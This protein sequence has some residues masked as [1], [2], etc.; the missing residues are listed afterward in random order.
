MKQ[1]IT[2]LAASIIDLAG[3]VGTVAEAAGRYG[4][5]KRPGSERICERC[6]RL[7]GSAFLALCILCDMG[8]RRLRI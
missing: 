4:T 7:T 5:W 1:T 3:E 6:G 2:R 8:E